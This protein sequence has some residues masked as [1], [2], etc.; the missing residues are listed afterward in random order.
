MLQVVVIVIVSTFIT[1]SIGI[2]FSFWEEHNIY[3]QFLLDIIWKFCA[4]AMFEIVD[5]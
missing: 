1:V 3:M 5:L 2:S 4:I